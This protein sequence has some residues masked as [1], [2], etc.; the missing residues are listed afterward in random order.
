M[1]KNNTGTSQKHMQIKKSSAQSFIAVVVASVVV[2]MTLV[3]AN[4]MY[5]TSKF[6][7]KV[8]GAL[9]DTK[10]QLVANIE[11]VDSLEKSFAALQNGD[12]L[13]AKQPEDKKNSEII[14]DSLPSVYDFPEIAS[15]VNRLAEISEV[16]LVAFQ[17]TDLGSDATNQSTLVEP[18]KIPFSV[19]V[20]GSYSAIAK[21]LLNSERNIRPIIVK[22]VS[23]SVSGNELSASVSA[24]TSYQPAFDITIQKEVIR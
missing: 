1:T 7:S 21:F 15:S 23:L 18:I 10:L 19:E 9:E 8:Q 12:N 24:E 11:A 3:L 22:S 6:N 4:I 5:D 13:I 14:L 2:S 20:K 17:G 16:E